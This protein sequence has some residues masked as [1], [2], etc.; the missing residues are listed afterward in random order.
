MEPGISIIN[1]VETNK[2]QRKRFFFGHWTWKTTVKDGQTSEEEKEEEKNSRK[3]IGPKQ[4]KWPKPAA[5]GQRDIF[6]CNS[7]YN[8]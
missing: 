5:T 7:R 2:K 3:F 4:N 8:D 1:F 6:E